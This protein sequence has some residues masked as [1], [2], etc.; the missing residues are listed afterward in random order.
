L[1][2]IRSQSALDAEMVQ[3]Q[4]DGGHFLGKVPPYVIRTDEQSGESPSFTLRFDYHMAPALERGIEIQCKESGNGKPPADGG[5]RVGN[6]T[7]EH[8]DLES[9]SGNLL[10]LFGPI[11][12]PFQLREISRRTGR[13]REYWSGCHT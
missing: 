6:P 8:I 1:P 4:F 11:K 2:E 7:M 9:Q 3:L 13:C 10:L 5:R 12:Y